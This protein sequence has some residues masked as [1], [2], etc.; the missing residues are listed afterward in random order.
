MQCPEA[1]LFDAETMQPRS[2][3][4]APSDTWIGNDR[5]IASLRH[6][7]RSRGRQLWVEPVVSVP[8]QVEGNVEMRD[9]TFFQKP[10]RAIDYPTHKGILRHPSGKRLLSRN[11]GHPPAMTHSP[12]LDAQIVR[13]ERPKGFPERRTLSVSRVVGLDP[14]S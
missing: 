8:F 9:E 4:L 3:R 10:R 11:E 12:Q 7:A 13:Q 2:T 1:G 14:A 6:G 5:Q